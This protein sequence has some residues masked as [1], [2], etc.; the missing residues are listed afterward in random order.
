MRRVLLEQITWSDIEE[1]IHAEEELLRHEPGRS[2][3]TPEEYFTAILTKL[4][5]DSEF[6]YPISERYDV[7]LWAAQLAVGKQLCSGR[8]EEDVLIRVFTAYRL[9]L[10]G[11]SFGAIGKVMNRDHSTIIHYVRK[12]MADMTSIPGVYSKE[13]SMYERMTEL[14]EEA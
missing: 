1:I 6:R 5:G 3:D 12:R 2:Y 13:L 10:E 4:R 7:V 14:L 11:Y 9:R 8:A